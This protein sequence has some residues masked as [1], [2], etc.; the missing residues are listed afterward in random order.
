M[1]NLLIQA[2]NLTLVGMGTVFVFLTVLVF[3]T[4]GMS[5]LALRFF[6]PESAVTA[7]SPSEEE[8]VAISAAIARYRART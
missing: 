7:G 1:S 8:L 4:R 6:P 5:A 3:A 2:L